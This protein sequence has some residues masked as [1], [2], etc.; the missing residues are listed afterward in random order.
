MLENACLQMCANIERYT[1]LVLKEA[2]TE[3]K[4]KAVKLQPKIVLAGDS[5]KL[6]PVQKQIRQIFGHVSN[7]PWIF[8][9]TIFEFYS[10]L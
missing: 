6:S 3:L 5:S 1:K 8:F 7:S 9:A 10:R 2:A 4:T